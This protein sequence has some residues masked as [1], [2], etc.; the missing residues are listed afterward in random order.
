MSIANNVWCNAF[1]VTFPTIRLFVVVMIAHSFQGILLCCCFF[2]LQLLTL[3][4]FQKQFSNYSSLTTFF[5]PIPKL[6]T[7][8]YFPSVHICH[9]S[10]GCF[11]PMYL[12]YSSL[13][14]SCLWFQLCNTKISKSPTPRKRIPVRI[15]RDYQIPSFAPVI[16]VLLPTSL[17]SLLWFLPQNS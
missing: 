17:Y 3:H 6:M 14:M 7:S 8:F 1:P 5:F 9:K 15:K 4:Q 12:S 13:P 2:L 16:E 10:I 11:L